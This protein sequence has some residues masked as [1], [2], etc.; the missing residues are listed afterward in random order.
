MHSN[1]QTTSVNDF[2]DSFC[3]SL[4]QIIAELSPCS[5]QK[6]FIVAV[7]RDLPESRELSLGDFK[8]LL[9]KRLQQLEEQGFLKVSGE[10][11][12]ITRPEDASIEAQDDTERTPKP[13]REE[14]IDLTH[15]VTDREADSKIV[16][17]PGSD[18]LQAQTNSD[19]ISDG[20]MEEI[21]ASI[22]QIIRDL[23]TG[24]A[25]EQK[26]TPQAQRDQEGEDDANELMGTPNRR[27]AAVTID[28]GEILDLTTE[29]GCLEIVEDDD[30][31]MVEATE[32]EEHLDREQ[33]ELATIE[34][35]LATSKTGQLSRST[36][37]LPQ[38]DETA[39]QQAKAGTGLGSS[40]K[41]QREPVSTLESMGERGSGLLLTE[42]A[43]MVRDIV[44]AL[45]LLALA[46]LS[47]MSWFDGK[48]SSITLLMLAALLL[49]GSAVWGWRDLSR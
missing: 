28:E 17:E 6:L 25:D 13:T 19:R 32:F 38:F 44:M 2:L 33:P 10:E 4:L 49:V 24:Q 39:A 30:Q 40:F 29:L 26:E 45:L 8:E 7:N 43:E 22:H 31:L 11:L 20:L 48:F 1:F 36:P 47:V 15:Q 27:D 3:R 12:V 42:T 23:E 9:H 18:F 14:S 37:N 16:T 21:V 34:K 35:G 41:D 5:E 46:V